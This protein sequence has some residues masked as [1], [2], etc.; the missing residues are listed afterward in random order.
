MRVAIC[1]PIRSGMVHHAFASSMVNTI[2]SLRNIEIT[3]STC[4]GNSILPD[5]R[6]VVVAG[7]MAQNADKV[8]FIDD[9]MSWTPMD[10]KFLITHPVD[11][12]TGLYVIRNFDD[13]VPC[14]SA[15]RFFNDT[16]RD[17]NDCGLIEVEG[18]GFGFICFDR[19]VFEKVAPHTLKLAAG[20]AI[21]TGKEWYREWFPYSLTEKDGEYH[22][23]G[24]DMGFAVLMRKAGLKLWLDPAIQLGHHE[25]GRVYRPN[26]DLYGGN[27]GTAG[28]KSAA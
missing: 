8:V 1:T 21:T 10:F 17:T 16:P 18:S 6:A 15:V 14:I 28:N 2:A 19:S 11:A 12:C 3:W 27:Y 4:I 23:V 9:D 26:L 13:N 24:E 5:A 22:R 20:D 7:A 25:G